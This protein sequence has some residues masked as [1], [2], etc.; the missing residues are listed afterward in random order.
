MLPRAQIERLIAGQQQALTY[1]REHPT[2]A[3]QHMAQRQGIAPQELG[4]A[5]AGIDIPNARMNH[6]L[7][8]QPDTGLAATAQY[9]GHRDAGQ[10]PAAQPAQYGG[11]DRGRFCPKGHPMTASPST[12][13][14]SSACRY[15]CPWPCL[16]SAPWCFSC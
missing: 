2:P 16:S 6:T 10:P 11:S 7:L 13:P 5:L 1:L 4:Q 9:L 3:W 15:G 12:A 14:R 8:T